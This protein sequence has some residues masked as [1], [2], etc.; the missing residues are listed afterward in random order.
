MRVAGAA[1]AAA[2][3]M[4][5]MGRLLLVSLALVLAAPTGARA[6]DPADQPPFGGQEAPPLVVRQ[7]PDQQPR[8]YRLSAEQAVGIA[9]RAVDGV[10]GVPRSEL[11]TTVGIRGDTWE[12]KFRDGE[13]DP[14]ALVV[15]DDA[16]G[17]VLEAWTGYQVE[18][19]L[20]RGY[21]GAVAGIVNAIWVWLPLC[22]VFMAPFVDP[23]RPLRLL[24]LDLIALLAFSVSL[25]FFNRG[26]I[27]VSVPLVYPVLGYL[28]LRLLV[29][30]FRP[31]ESRQRLVPF[32]GGNL[33]LAG[34]AALV[35]LHAVIALW[36]A[37]VIDVGLASVIGADRLADGE[38]VY[39][40]GS[41]SGEPIRVDVYGPVNYLAYVPFE[42]LL[43]WSGNWESVPAAR[44]ASL[45]FDLLTALG[46][47]VLGRRLRPWPEGRTL[48]AALAFAWLAYPFS[49]YALGSSFNDGLVA[50]L[51]VG[52]LLILSSAPARGGLAALAGLTKFGP[53]AL[54]PL[55]A[56]GT[57]DRRPR[58]LAAFAF[59]FLATAAAAVALVID[60]STLGDLYDRSLGYQATRSSPFSVWGQAPSLDPLQVLLQ[61]GAVAFGLALFLWP[62]RRDPVQVAALAGAALIAVQVPATHWFYPYCLWFAP[63][64][65]VAFFAAYGGERGLRG[66]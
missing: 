12:V 51:V 57:G 30:G 39:G 41:A 38:F 1:G 64:A 58:T 53:L 40:V 47:F 19:K 66:A 31:R 37:K 56:A 50:L 46:L 32:A 28:F 49:L 5:Y 48:G 22:V 25:Y 54:A 8:G 17:E 34:I 61:V 15:I 63:G 33:L 20:A 29:A 44:I 7:K 60:G 27:G 45:T 42:Q 16:R 59:G 9:L 62:R 23:R 4:A 11:Q 43:P 14:K 24:H 35:A 13:G 36:E 2:K 26:D 3:I 18:T 21:P 10:G 55:L 65:L 52:S 6:Q